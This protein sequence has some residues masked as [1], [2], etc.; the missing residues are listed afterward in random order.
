MAA[1]SSYRRQNAFTLVEILVGSVILLVLVGLLLG[2]GEK[3][4]CFWHASEGKRNVQREILASIRTMEADLRHAAVTSNPETLI[5]RTTPAAPGLNENSSLFLLTCGEERDTET[6]TGL[7]AAG[8]F[9]AE[10]PQ[11][12]GRWN[13]YRFHAPEKETREALKS[14]S[15]PSLYARASATDNSTTEILGENIVGLTIVEEHQQGQPSLLR[16]TVTGMPGELPSSERASET[17]ALLKRKSRQAVSL[18]RLP[19]AVEDCT[20]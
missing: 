19:P 9:V 8:Y 11:K 16:I 4:S 1:L 17:P 7:S 6:G 15:L 12:K 3:I 18:V 10:S 13:L 2:M 20:P 5:I 14:N